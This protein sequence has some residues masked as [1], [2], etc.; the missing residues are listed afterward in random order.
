MVVSARRL[1]HTLMV[2]LNREILDLRV[3]A[4]IQYLAL[5]DQGLHER[6]G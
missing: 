3:N 4:H 6:N 2:N 5:R 1:V